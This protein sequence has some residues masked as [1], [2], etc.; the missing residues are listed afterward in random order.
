[1]KWKLLLCLL[2]CLALSS[3]VSAADAPSDNEEKIA[4]GL[5]LQ[6]EGR[7][8][9]SPCR[10]RSYYQ[11]EDLSPNRGLTAQLTELG[12]ADGKSLYVELQGALD[13]NR[14]R[15]RN[16][17][18]ARTESRC[19]E[20]GGPDELWRAAGQNAPWR[21]VAIAGE[22]LLTRP[23][24]PELKLA[25]TKVKSEDDRV[26]LVTPE[27]TEAVWR[28]R[29]QYCQDKTAGMLFGWRAEIKVDGEVLQ[30]CAWQR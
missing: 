26:E 28:L 30:G 3:G 12:L 11:L 14:L 18:L 5:L 24:M 27:K 10:H 6:H 4:K 22:L 17:N 15:A 1:M 7:M 20:A 13:D 16:L 9:F 2:A 8:I 21:F 29:R 23:G 25:Y 19:H